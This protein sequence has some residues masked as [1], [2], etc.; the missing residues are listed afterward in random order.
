MYRDEFSSLIKDGDK[1]YL[2]DLPEFLSE[3]YSGFIEPRYTKSGKL[4]AGGEVYFS[5]ISVTTPAVYGVLPSTYFS[6]GLGN[7][8]IYV[9]VTPDDITLSVPQR[10]RYSVKIQSTK[11][12]RG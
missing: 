2:S 1:P 6:Q 7:R 8:F 3:L 5:M 12:R 11:T 10:K 4:E 9:V